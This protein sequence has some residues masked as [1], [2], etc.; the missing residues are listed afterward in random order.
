MKS[1]SGLLFSTVISGQ[2][3][4]SIVTWNLVQMVEHL[5]D[6][7]VT[8]VAIIIVSIGVYSSGSISKSV[9][10]ATSDPADSLMLPIIATLI[11]VTIV[12]FSKVRVTGSTRLVVVVSGTRMLNITMVTVSNALINLF[13]YSVLHRSS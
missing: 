7:L 5:I 6:V 2:T 4:P 3:R 10:V 8:V 9:R 11:L 12:S 13:S 1:T